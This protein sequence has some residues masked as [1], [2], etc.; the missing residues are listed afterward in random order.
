VLNDEIVLTDSTKNLTFPVEAVLEHLTSYMTL[1]AGDV[2]HF[3]TAVKSVAP[4][5]FPS[6]RHLDMSRIDG[7]FSVEIDG[8]GRLDNPIAREVPAQQ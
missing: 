1:E 7:V 8:I 3:G 4:E 5:R 2:V 6:I